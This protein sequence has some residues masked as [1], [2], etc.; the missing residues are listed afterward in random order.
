MSFFSKKIEYDRVGAVILI[1]EDGAILMQLRDLKKG[2]R[3]SGKWVPP[4]GH[5]EPNENIV[6]CARR[7]FLEETGYNCS[8]LKFLTKFDDY[9]KGWPP[10]SLTF[11]WE[12]YDGNQKLQCFEGQELKFICRSEADSY[13]IPK[14]LYKVWDLALSSSRGE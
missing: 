8:N 13:D 6:S 12:N 7:E 1:R 5:A 11:F 14:N 10:Y 2:L 9:V 4:G 3:H